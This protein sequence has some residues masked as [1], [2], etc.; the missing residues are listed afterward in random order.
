[1]ELRYCEEMV[2]LAISLLCWLIAACAHANVSA[3]Y[4]SWYDDPTTTMTVQWHAEPDTETDALHLQKPD[5]SWQTSHAT[6]RPLGDQYLLVHTLSLTNLQPDTLYHF[7]LADE[8]TTYAFRTAPQELTE[9]LRF[10]IG[11]D[12]YG[13]PKLFRKMSQTAAKLEPLFAVLGGDLAYALNPLPLQLRSNPLKKWRQFLAE[14]QELMVGAGGRLIPF[15]VVPGNHDI[16]PDDYALFFDLF[17]FPAKQL[18]RTVDFGT[19]L[20]LVLLDTGHFHPVQGRQTLWLDQALANRDHVPFVWAIYHVGAYPSFYSDQDS[21][22]KKVR[23]HWCPLFDQHTLQAAFEHHSH[24]FKE[25]YP[26]KGGKV[27][28]AG[29]LYFGDGA[30]GVTPRIAQNRWYL[31]VTDRKNHVYC[32]EM[33]RKSASIKAVGITGD[34]FEE[35]AIQAR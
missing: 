11:G 2:R 19:Y 9:P 18:Y 20:S 6:H 8:E 34:V 4:L 16:A 32:V 10:L 7:R 23:T 14:W 26:L 35:T 12:L 27:D 21:L 29:T 3:L 33:D 1:M 28:P 22:A 5:G 15:L 13:S 25:T 17:A 31:K 30:W 24:T